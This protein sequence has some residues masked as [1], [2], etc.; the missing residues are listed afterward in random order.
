M[1][2]LLI[3]VVVIL[4]WN[5]VWGYCKGFLL[6][7]YSMVSWIIAFLLVT[8]LTPY[9]TEYVAPYFSGADPVGGIVYFI[10]FLIT[11]IILKLVEY[12]LGI[13]SKIPVL[14]GIN[15]IVGLAAGGIK[16]C[17]LIWL[18]FA[19]IAFIGTTQTGKSIISYIYEEEFLIW[20]YEN[21]LLLYIMM[22]FV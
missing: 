19:V 18:L 6:V 16:G 22:L 13:V 5:L 20:I 9:I 10:S 11:I 3:A 12:A 17:L 2:W 8:W 4:A 7:A 15:K 21:N 1:N 14:D